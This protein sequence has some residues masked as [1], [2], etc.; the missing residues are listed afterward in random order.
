MIGKMASSVFAAVELSGEVPKGLETLRGSTGRKKATTHP[1]AEGPVVGIRKLCNPP[2]FGIVDPEL[3]DRDQRVHV[4]WE[5]KDCVRDT[6]TS[7]SFDNPTVE[8]PNVRRLDFQV[9]QRAFQK[10]TEERRSGAFNNDGRRVNVV[11]GNPLG[12]TRI[13]ANRC[14]NQVPDRSGNKGGRAGRG[15][16]R[17][18][19]R[20][21]RRGDSRERK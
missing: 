16:G 21:Q 7:D 1:T 15:C 8:T 10:T 13:V 6:I 14:G 18:D 5:I 3:T 4:R 17:R 2:A 20:R 12:L 9:L 11:D 19:R